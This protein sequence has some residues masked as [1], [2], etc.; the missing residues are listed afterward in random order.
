MY[1]PAACCQTLLYYSGGAQLIWAQQ[2]PCC[3]AAMKLGSS[4]GGIAQ[5]AALAG[6]RRTAQ[7]TQHT[8]RLMLQSRHLQACRSSRVG[9]A[10]KHCIHCYDMRCCYDRQAGSGFN[11]SIGRCRGASASASLQ[12]LQQSQAVLSAEAI[13]V[14][15]PPMHLFKSA[16]S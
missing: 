4:C 5:M 10:H 7:N 14:H 15:P 9:L 3:T 1:H 6:C 11:Q 2:A 16:S 12:L 13:F 8:H